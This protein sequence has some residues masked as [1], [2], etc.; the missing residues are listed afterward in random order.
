M[1]KFNI[2]SRALIASLI[3]IGIT[4]GCSSEN[5]KFTRV[6]IKGKVYKFETAD[7]KDSRSKGLMF[8]KKL[9]ADS[10]MLFVFP[11]E[12]DLAF[13][14]RNTLIPLEI[15]F[16][17]RGFKII[18]IEKMEPLDETSIYSSGPAMYTIETNRGFFGRHDIKPG[19]TIKLLDPVEYNPD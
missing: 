11:Y 9:G 16:I 4:A 5:A 18:N 3:V 14:M 1:C 19:D 12:K 2:L 13:Y 7:S 15:A 17:D 6:E 10:G 8:R